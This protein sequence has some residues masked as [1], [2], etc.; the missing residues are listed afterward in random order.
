MGLPEMG[1]NNAPLVDVLEEDLSQFLN[2]ANDSTL[3]DDDKLEKELR[4]ITRRTTQAEIG[5]KAE[6]TVVIS[7]LS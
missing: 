2:R 5:K 6:V 7:R 1:R 3:A 4:T